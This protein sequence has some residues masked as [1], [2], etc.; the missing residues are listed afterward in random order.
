MWFSRHPRALCELKLP[1]FKWRYDSI[2]SQIASSLTLKGHT[3][4]ADLPNFRYSLPSF[5]SAQS[6]RPDIVLLSETEITFL[7]L[8]VPFEG[9]FQ[10]AQDR[11]AT[12]Y[13]HLLDLAKTN[14]FVA[15]LSCFE[16][17]SRG[18]TSASWE[19]FVKE[20]GLGAALKK[21]ILETAIRCSYVIWT[22]RFLP[23][24]NPPS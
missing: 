2:L 22:T 12:K 5:L 8:T 18:L 1:R 17:G 11:K 24:E 15:R 19:R 6:L 21:S 7:E 13:A 16:V 20:F 14:G 4:H 23:W 3:V 10:A 9:N